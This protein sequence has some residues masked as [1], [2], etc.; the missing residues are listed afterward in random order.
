MK[1]M[2]RIV[3]AILISCIVISSVGYTVV[4]FGCPKMS[5]AK[6]SAC[7]SCKTSDAKPAKPKSCCKAIVE[8]KVVHTD[9]TKPNDSKPVHT[10]QAV[11]PPPI[12]VVTENADL[13][14]VSRRNLRF[15]TPPAPPDAST[16]RAM[17]S[18]FLI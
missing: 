13:F 6:T 16:A 1:V 17:L 2:H 5:S 10:V 4:S 11:L 3:S 8:H 7:S 18:T 12:L 9:V 15:E 14:G